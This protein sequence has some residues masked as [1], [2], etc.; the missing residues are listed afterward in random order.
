MLKCNCGGE[1]TLK[2]GFTGMDWETQAGEGSGFGWEISLVC[3]SCNRVYPI[4]YV[5]QLG[6]FSPMNDQNKCVK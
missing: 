6:D 2:T 5:K 3:E 1:L 4:G